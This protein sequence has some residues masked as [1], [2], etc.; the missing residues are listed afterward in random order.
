VKSGDTL[1]GIAAR[2]GT[3]ATRLRN[4][5][6]LS[7]DLIRIGQVLKLP[8]AGTETAAP[9]PAPST[10]PRTYTIKSGDSLSGIAARFGTTTR[11]LMNLNDITDAN[12]IRIG[13]VIKLP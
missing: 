5:N 2:F 1:S 6:D 7:S 9:A 10:A 3:T 13:Q 12:R 11:K 8:G 4:L